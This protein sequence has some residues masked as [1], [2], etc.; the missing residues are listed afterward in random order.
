MEVV[1]A[2]L[3]K[4]ACRED[5]DGGCDMGK[6]EAESCVANWVAI[7]KVVWPFLYS[8]IFAWGS[9]LQPPVLGLPYF[10]MAGLIGIVQGLLLLLPKGELEG[11]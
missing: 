4:H 10:F 3:V 11:R 7:L 6:G 5:V 1:H 8:R 9:Q 2:F